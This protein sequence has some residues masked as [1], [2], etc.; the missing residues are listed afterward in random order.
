MSAFPLIVGIV[1][2]VIIGLIAA[3]V[4]WDMLVGKI[5]LSKLLSDDPSASISRFQFLVFT[6]VIGLSYLLVV[7]VIAGS[8]S[9]SLPDIPSG[10]AALLGISGG[11]Y[12]LSKGIQKT[13]ETSQKNTQ[14]TAQQQQGAGQNAT[15][16]GGQNPTVAGGGHC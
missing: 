2:T 4:V 12:V 10:V 3:V 7:L 14:V 11:S 13:A 6:F 5:D 1:G 15:V 16:P 8:N 9:V